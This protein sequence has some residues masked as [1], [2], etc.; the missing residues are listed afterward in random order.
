MDDKSGNIYKSA[1]VQD[2]SRGINLHLMS[3]G[4]LY[5]GDSIRI[6]L[7]GLVLSEYAG[8]MQIDSVKVVDNIVKLATLKKH[9]T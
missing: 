2:V 8:M 1:Y 3:S 9:T 7:K 5:V 6:K 4:G